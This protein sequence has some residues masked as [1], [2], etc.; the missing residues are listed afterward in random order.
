MNQQAKNGLAAMHLA[1]QEDRVAVAQLLKK[2]GAE[3]GFNTAKCRG[4]FS[5]ECALC[6]AAR[7]R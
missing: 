7:Y 3:V 1:A 4:S 5:C 6:C 2:N